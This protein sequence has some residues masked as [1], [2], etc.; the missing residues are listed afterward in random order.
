MGM[1]TSVS[2]ERTPLVSV[3]WFRCSGN[4]L[5]SFFCRFQI[6][7]HSTI[8]ISLSKT[9]SYSYGV[10]NWLL[11]A[12][13]RLYCRQHQF[14]VIFFSYYQCCFHRRWHRCQRQR[15]RRH[16]HSIFCSGVQSHKIDFSI[17]T[18]LFRVQRYYCFVD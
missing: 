1:S 12:V 7:I 3:F 17:F 15:Q 14:I 9:F 5:K 11:S 13:G 6:S 10:G 18:K 16:C 2:L 8:F 4:S